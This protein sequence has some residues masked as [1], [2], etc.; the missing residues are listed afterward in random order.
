MPGDAIP[1]DL[2]A[3]DRQARPGRIPNVVNRECWIDAAHIHSFSASRD[4]DLR[5]GLAL[6]KNAHWL[7][8][9]GLWSIDDEYRVLV[10]DDLFEE[11]AP[12]QMP[13]NGFVGK[14]LSLPRNKEHWPLPKYL[15]AHRRQ[16]HF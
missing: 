16:H 9:A 15:A 3:T 1:D 13:L 2:G 4:N 11:A 5:N 10:A 7:F 8:D 12:N 6:C 14:Q